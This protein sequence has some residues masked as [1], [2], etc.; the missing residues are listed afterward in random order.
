MWSDD[1]PD[2]DFT[3][4]LETVF[5]DVEAQTIWF[6]NPLTRGRSAATIYVASRPQTTR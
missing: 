2:D 6:D 5:T 3:S 1:P 4:L